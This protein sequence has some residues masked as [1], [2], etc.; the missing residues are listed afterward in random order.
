[1]GRLIAL[2][3]IIRSKQ[4]SCCMLC[5]RVGLLWAIL[6]RTLSCHVVQSSQML[7]GVLLMRPHVVSRWWARIDIIV[8]KIIVKW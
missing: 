3:D 5:M 6:K 1:M 8:R 4:Y 2:N 7:H